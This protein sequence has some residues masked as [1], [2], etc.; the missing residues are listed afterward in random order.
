MAGEFLVF[1][2]PATGMDSR[3]WGACWQDI[4]I[5][6]KLLPA[7][8]PLLPAYRQGQWQHRPPTHGELQ[9]MLRHILTLGGVES[10]RS[11]VVTPHGLKATCLS[12]CAKANVPLSIRRVL[13]HHAKPGERMVHTYARDAVAGPLRELTKLLTFIS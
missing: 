8:Q 7:G 1:V 9:G 12:W 2:A 13:G 4:L 10:P 11:L 3:N 5:Q 6:C